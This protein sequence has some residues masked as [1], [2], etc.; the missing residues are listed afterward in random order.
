MG[1]IARLESLDRPVEVR[2][3]AV[4]SLPWGHVGWRWKRAHIRV[5]DDLAYCGRT[6]ERWNR[7]NRFTPICRRCIAS[8][9]GD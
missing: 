9:P 3:F 8:L 6:T 7:P 4:D 2:D 1:K 5:Y